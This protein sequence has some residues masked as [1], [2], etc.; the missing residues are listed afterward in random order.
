MYKSCVPEKKRARSEGKSTRRLVPAEAD[1][2]SCCSV[3]LCADKRLQSRQIESSHSLTNPVAMINKYN[4]NSE[5]RHKYSTITTKSLALRSA[6]SP[7]IDLKQIS[8]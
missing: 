3:W 1:L 5:Y 4:Y 7:S 2:E 6:H 8:L